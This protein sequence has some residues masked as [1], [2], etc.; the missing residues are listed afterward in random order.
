MEGELRPRTCSAGKGHGGLLRLR[1]YMAG[2]GLGGGSGAQAWVLHG[3]REPRRGRSC[4]GPQQAHWGPRGQV[5]CWL[6]SPLIPSSPEGPLLSPPI[7]VLFV[8]PPP[9]VWEPLPYPGSPSGVLVLSHLLFSSPLLPSHVL[10]GCVGIP[11]IPL[12]IQGPPLV[13]S[14]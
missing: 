14:R 10:P 9:R 12:G 2:K 6:H 3:Q 1:T 7:P 5:R 8:G 11:L 4:P 13:P